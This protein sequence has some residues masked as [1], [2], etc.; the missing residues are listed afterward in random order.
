MVWRSVK[1]RL[2]KERKNEKI[3][4]IKSIL[5]GN[6]IMWKHQ[7]IYTWIVIILLHKNYKQDMQIAKWAIRLL[8]FILHS[9]TCRSSA[10][11]TMS[12]KV[13]WNEAQLTPRS[14]PSRTYFTTAST[15]PKR[16]VF[17]WVRRRMSSAGDT[18]FFLRA[19][20]SQTRT[21]WSSDADTT[22]SSLGWKDAH[23]T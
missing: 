19:P 1:E 9:F 18:V 11:E 20:I 22:R 2:Q 13:G 23:M 15:P 5:L 7:I 21:V 3:S 10:P 14:W 12:G 6:S 16:S 17:I 4:T 8:P